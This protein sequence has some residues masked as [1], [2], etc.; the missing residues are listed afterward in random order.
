VFDIPATPATAAWPKA[1]ISSGI[2]SAPGNIFAPMA[3]PGIFGSGDMDGDNDIDL[4]VSGDG[5]P[6]VYWLEQVAPGR[7]LTH[8][9]QPALPQAGGTEIVDLDGDG[10]NETI[11]TGYES[12]AVYI[13][14][15]DE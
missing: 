3:A 15:Q 5:D 13:F 10:R 12:N 7:F 8:V 1:K 9:L 14:Q 11:V 2:E 4:V 6:D